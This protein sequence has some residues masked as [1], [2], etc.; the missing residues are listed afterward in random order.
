[1]SLSAAG[2]PFKKRGQVVPLY[3]F[4]GVRM[5]QGR[6]CPRQLTFTGPSAAIMPSRWLHWF[7]LELC[8]QTG[9]TGAAAAAPFA[10]TLTSNVQHTANSFANPSK[11]WMK[12]G[13]KTTRPWLKRPFRLHLALIARRESQS[14]VCFLTSFKQTSPTP[15]LM[16]RK[17]RLMREINLCKDWCHMINSELSALLR[18]HLWK[19]KWLHGCQELH[20]NTFIIARGFDGVNLIRRNYFIGT[21]VAQL[22]HWS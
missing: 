6:V 13:S 5:R 9:F 1:M 7:I 8:G 3:L 12:E 17:S 16:N 22:F 20:S 11:Y 19:C 15:D 18:M 2:V 21:T 10:L 14:C 4:Q